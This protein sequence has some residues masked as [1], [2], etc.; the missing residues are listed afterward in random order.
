MANL[1]QPG[2]NIRCTC[3][4]WFR[5]HHIFKCYRASTMSHQTVPPPPPTGS[6]PPSLRQHKPSPI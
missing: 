4:V 2:L 6:P 5:S 1:P 3:T